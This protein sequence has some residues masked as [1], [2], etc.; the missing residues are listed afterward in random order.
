ME[1][2]TLISVGEV[3]AM[4]SISTREVWRRSDSGE[5]PRPVHLGTRTRR[6]IRE[7]IEAIIE[8][9]KRQRDVRS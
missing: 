8:R 1:T 9:A 6:W 2:T 3:A 7:E 4:L 5:L